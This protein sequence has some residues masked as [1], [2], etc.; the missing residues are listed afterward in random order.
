MQHFSELYPLDKNDWR[1]RPGVL[2]CHPV[3]NVSLTGNSIYLNTWVSE[4]VLHKRIGGFLAA[5]KNKQ[6][7]TDKLY[8]YRA[9]MKMYSENTPHQDGPK[10]KNYLRAEKQMQIAAVHVENVAKQ[11]LKTNKIKFI[12]HEAISEIESGTSSGSQQSKIEDP[13]YFIDADVVSAFLCFEY[14]ESMAR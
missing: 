1:G 13:Q 5:F 9:L 6:H 3:D 2:A 4:C 8:H 10:R 11:Q 12:P 7:L 14:T